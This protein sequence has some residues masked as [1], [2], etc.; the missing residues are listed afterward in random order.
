[1]T[2]GEDV[3][4]IIATQPERAWMLERA[5][6]SI[7]RQ[8][9]PPAHVIVEVDH[10]KQGAAKTR[11]S[12]LE[13]VTTPWVA[14]LD[15][16]DWFHP[17]HLETLCV[18]ANSSGADLIGT[19]PEPHPPGQQDALYC[20]HKGIR[21]YGPVNVAWGPEQLD[22]FDA[23]RGRSCPHCGELRGSFIM[24]T[25]LIRMTYVDKIGGFPEP[26]SMGEGF[27]GYGAEDYLF[28][29]ALLDAGARF[30]H[31]TGVRTWS[32]RVRNT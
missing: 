1:V 21:V 14:I 27:A 3:S 20:C 25:N 29:L 22:H 18:G 5:L 23:R 6:E 11:N 16:D 7:D 19:Y 31:V 32:Y 9:V 24:I 15:D 30:H 13:R 4:V 10:G 26:G 12:A 2:T 28:L 8:T 17:N